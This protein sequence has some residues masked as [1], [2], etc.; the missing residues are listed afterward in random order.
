MFTNITKKYRL[1]NEVRWTLF[2]A[3]SIGLFGFASAKHSNRICRKVFV[4]IT[5]DSLYQFIGEENIRQVLAEGAVPATAGTQVRNISLSGLEKKL[6]Q[7]PYLQGADVS[8]DVA[9]NLLVTVTQKNPVARIFND[10]GT[11]YYIS[12]KG[13]LFPESKSYTARVLIV[14][15]MPWAWQQ[16]RDLMAT[17]EGKAFLELLNDLK[18]NKF[19]SAQIA[20]IELDYRGELTLIPQ[21]GNQII[22]FGN[23][24]NAEQKLSKLFAF[25]Q[26]IV[27]K[28]GWNQ[29]RKV[30]VKFQNQIVCEKRS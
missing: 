20:E 3:I 25:Y 14:K 29:Y 30:S 8:S 13:I 21:I 19:W 10:Q 2:L 11:D 28:A 1:K 26:Q 17:E 27:A 18:S 6:E 23:P 5:N 4:T 24:F 15:G 16:N 22:E 9:G 12:D 7:N